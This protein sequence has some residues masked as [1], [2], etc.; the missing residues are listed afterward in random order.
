MQE[1]QQYFNVQQ[2]LYILLFRR[3]LFIVNHAV[4]ITTA[5]LT[6]LQFAWHKNRLV[7]YEIKSEE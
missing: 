2:G 1:L 4:L 3:N 7:K 6:N 5:N